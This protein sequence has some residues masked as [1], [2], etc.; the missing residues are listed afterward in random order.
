MKKKRKKHAPIIQITAEQSEAFDIFL[1]LL[2]LII[3]VL[4]LASIWAV[5]FIPV[6]K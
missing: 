3:D 1:S 2:A 6:G 5:T 4:I